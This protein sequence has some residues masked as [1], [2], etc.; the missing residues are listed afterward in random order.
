VTLRAGLCSRR[1]AETWIAAGRVA[2]NGK[3]IASPARAITLAMRSCA[4]LF[5][6]SGLIL[7][8]A[9]QAAA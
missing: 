6:W 8:L 4:G 1:E 9:A 5:S 7:G 3:V 2:V